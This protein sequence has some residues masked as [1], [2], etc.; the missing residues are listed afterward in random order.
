MTKSEIF[1][2]AHKLAKTFEGDYQACFSLALKTVYA[3]MESAKEVFVAEWIALKNGLTDRFAMKMLGSKA[4]VINGKKFD[5]TRYE[6]K[7]E[8]EKAYLLDTFKYGY[9]KDI[10]VPK[11]Q[12]EVA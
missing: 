5:T 6:V 8:T 7:S 11:S 10:W 4:K 12:C 1:K 2:A 9:S 3:N